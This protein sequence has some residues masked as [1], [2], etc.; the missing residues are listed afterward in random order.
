[1]S[2]LYEAYTVTTPPPEASKTELP[3]TTSVAGTQKVSANDVMSGAAA[4]PSVSVAPIPSALVAGDGEW[5]TAARAAVADFE[6]ISKQPAAELGPDWKRFVQSLPADV[7]KAAA[8]APAA[9]AGTS[10]ADSKQDPSHVKQPEPKSNPLSPERRAPPPKGADSGTPD[11]HDLITRY[12][13]DTVL[14]KSWLAPAKKG[15]RCLTHSF[16]CKLPS[17]MRS[18]FC[19]QTR[20]RSPQCS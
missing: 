13:S 17:H 16:I 19:S 5:A 20:A 4:K 9:A 1:M 8:A 10:S 2:L 14:Y 6:R 15:M 18:V 3:A 11:L 12:N 7:I